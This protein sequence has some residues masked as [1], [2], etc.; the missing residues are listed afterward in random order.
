MKV[1]E[2]TPTRLT[3]KY[4]PL[5]NWIFA[6]LILLFAVG[7][8]IGSLTLFSELPALLLGSLCLLVV[9]LDTAN[10]DSVICT[11]DRTA[12]R[13]KIKSRNLFRLT[14][15][16][17]PLADITAVGQV[18]GGAQGVVLVIAGENIPLS[19]RYASIWGGSKEDA[20]IA[21]QIRNFLNLEAKV[22][23]ST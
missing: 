5:F 22:P 23:S 8:A 12:Q 1:L 3:L 20:T 17:Y 10:A 7:L 16:E 19:F 11:F 2:Q 15:F 4:Q 14:E 6:G 13:V 9:A 18:L 21:E